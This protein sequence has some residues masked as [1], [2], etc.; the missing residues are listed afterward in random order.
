MMAKYIWLKIT[1]GKNMKKILS[2]L[3]AVMMIFSSAAALSMISYADDNTGALG[4]N[5]TWLYSAGTLIISGKGD[6][7]D[8]DVP[9][10]LTEVIVNFPEIHYVDIREGVTSICKDCFNNFDELEQVWIPTTV[11][12]IDVTAFLGCPNLKSFTVAFGNKDFLPNDDISRSTDGVLYNIDKTKIICFPRN[13]SII[14]KEKP[15]F[16][17]PGTVSEIGDY[18]F[19]GCAGLKKIEFETDCQLQTIGAN[20][21]ANCTALESV[22]FTR[23]TDVTAIGSNAFSGCSALTEFKFWPTLNSKKL[24]TDIFKGT[25]FTS[26]K[27]KVTFYGKK[28]EFNSINLPFPSGTVIEY[29][30]GENEFSIIKAAYIRYNPNGGTMSHPL[31]YSVNAIPITITDVAPISNAGRFQGWATDP[32]SSQVVYRAGNTR[33]T[34]DGSI[35]LYAVYS[36]TIVINYDANGGTGAPTPTEV[37]AAGTVNLS[38]VTPS[39]AGYTFKGWSKDKN[40]TTA[41]WK[42]GASFTV[43]QSVTLYAVWEDNGPYDLFFYSQGN[44]IAKV[45]KEKNVPYTLSLEPSYSGDSRFVFQGWSV[46]ENDKTVKYTKGQNYT[47]NKSQ[48]F[49]AVY[50]NVGPYKVFVQTAYGDDSYRTNAYRT[51]SYSGESFAV[52]VTPVNREGYNFMGWIDNNGRRYQQGDSVCPSGEDLYLEIVWEKINLTKNT[53]LNLGPIVQK[54]VKFKNKAHIVAEASNLPDDYR[55]VLIDGKTVIT[56][57][58]A[59]SS[60]NARIDIT[61]GELKSGF[62]YYVKVL[63]PGDAVSETY[64]GDS[65]RTLSSKISVGVDDN[66]IWK[67]IAFFRMFF[68]GQPTVEIK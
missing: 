11:K 48:K 22:D 43:D 14:T 29:V 56:D 3:L 8:R 65:G 63:G 45:Q 47:E 10:A 66:L 38:S 57:V 64:Q 21:F 6:M 37:V 27:G 58:A 68:G 54:T 25:G 34:E 33:K 13:S 61:T 15:S 31:D 9:E 24:G 16:I 55:L 41:D 20:A 26:S 44:E 62:T 4:E 51:Q 67:I 60:G 49:Y 52:N 1:G 2:L 17:L 19:E 7:D 5:L 39:R 40:A 50:K 28:A 18:A 36:N 12:T 23:Q 53:T 46:S 32:K 59:D 35:V 30:N 42:A